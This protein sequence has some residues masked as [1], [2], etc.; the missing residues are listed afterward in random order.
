MKKSQSNSKITQVSKE[1]STSKNKDTKEVSQPKSAV[2][3]K[4]SGI[5]IPSKAASNTNISQVSKV[6]GKAGYSSVSKEKSAGKQAKSDSN[7]SSVVG[8]RGKTKSPEISTKKQVKEEPKKMPIKR[9]DAL[10][11]ADIDKIRNLSKSTK[12]ESEVKVVDSAKKPT[13][14]G[15]PHVDK[16]QSQGKDQ[17]N[18]LNNFFYFIFLPLTNVF[19]INLFVLRY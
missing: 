13:G 12:K 3:K 7:I 9:R 18:I 11:E 8:Y 10:K 14:R 5:Q 19:N 2:A 16:S 17:V 1:K 6:G 4:N 15:R